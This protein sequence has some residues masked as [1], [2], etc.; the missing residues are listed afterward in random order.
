MSAVERSGLSPDAPASRL[1]LRPGS[2]LH[3]AGW[4]GEHVVFNE[5]SGQTHL[6]DGVR[7][8][9]L[10]LLGE[11]PRTEVQLLDELHAALGLDAA[12]EAARVLAD[13]LAGFERHGLIDRCPP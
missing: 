7:A 1:R 6:L 12:G 10:H 8:F 5:H 2:R 3:W 13:V 4:D 9:V 11:A